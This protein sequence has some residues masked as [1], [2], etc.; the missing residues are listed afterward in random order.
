[1][2]NYTIPAIGMGTFGSDRYDADTVANAVYTAIKLGYR[3]FDCA[4]VYGN[5]KEIGKVFARAIEEKLV[6]RKDLYIT[7][8]VWNDHHDKGEVIK[9]CKKSIED[10]GVGYIDLYFMHWPFPNYHAKGCDVSSRNAD[11]RPFFAEEFM[12]A[13]KEMEWL[14]EQ[15][16]AKEIGMSNMTIPKLN[17]VLDKCA[18]MPFAHEM[19]IHPAFQQKE[20]V[21][22]CIEKGI[23]VIGYCPIGSPNRPDRDKTEEDINDLQLPSIVEIAKK[24]NV[25][26]AEVC[27]KW[28]SQRGIVPIPFATQER[29]ILSNLR[30]LSSADLTQEEMDSIAKDDHNCRLVKGHVFLWNGAKDW[31]DLWDIQGTL[32]KWNKVGENWVVVK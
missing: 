27:L 26:P 22:Y 10:L 2:T 8:K 3:M 18:I 24:R 28:A 6:E 12:S 17:A 23:K 19:E 7:S 4:E 29:N 5:E 32:T 1:M 20:L 9:A 30:S 16:L 11:S 31:T 25:H 15:G 21:A 13:W 14:K